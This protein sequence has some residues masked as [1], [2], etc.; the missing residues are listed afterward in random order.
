MIYQS[1]RGNQQSFENVKSQRNAQI[2]KVFH[3]YSF[4]TCFV[5]NSYS[6]RWLTL[7]SLAFPALFYQSTLLARPL[8]VP[9][10]HRDQPYQLTA[11]IH[12][13]QA[14]HGQCWR[15]EIRSVFYKICSKC[16][17]TDQGTNKLEI[18]S[19]WLNI[20]SCT[21]T[22]LYLFFTLAHIKK[23]L[24]SWSITQNYLRTMNWICWNIDL[25][26]CSA[27]CS[28]GAECTDT[29]TSMNRKVCLIWCLLITFLRSWR[30][31]CCCLVEWC[32]PVLFDPKQ[33]DASMIYCQ[34]FE[35]QI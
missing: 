31:M 14:L 35:A 9:F 22:E 20:A 24:Y 29:L 12:S 15:I 7:F 16:T 4:C 34:L 6:V 25:S 2:I 18:D 17:E 33:L 10:K 28:L 21:C 23:V 27:L 11:R 19:S 5:Y 13:S 30:S 3:I 32:V 26:K 1:K 8:V